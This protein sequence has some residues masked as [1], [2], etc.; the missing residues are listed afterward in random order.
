MIQREEGV[1]TRRQ[2]RR[3][4]R[5]C[6]VAGGARG[7][8]ARGHVIGIG[9]P[10]KVR[11]VTR[12]AVCRRAGK[13]VVDVAQSAGD[14]G[15][16]TRQ[17]KRRV[18]VVECRAGPGGRCVAGI[19]GCRKARRSVVGIR[20][21]VPVSLMAAIARGRERRV[22]VVHMTCR[23]RNRRMSSGERKCGVVVIEGGWTPPAGR[24]TDRT[25]CREAG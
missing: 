11:L 1:V 19:A 2:G 5:R 24:V 17:W 16:R 23:T 15:V 12:V 8:P 22:V 7:G 21:S 4:P 9:C 18:V 25:I 3:N 13:H 6:R 10:S 14:S 20:R